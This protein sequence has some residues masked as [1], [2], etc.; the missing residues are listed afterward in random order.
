MRVAININI[1]IKMII[2]LD[3]NSDRV[4]FIYKIKNKETEF[5][6]Q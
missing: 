6:K 3:C 4:R 1:I 2:N 5:R